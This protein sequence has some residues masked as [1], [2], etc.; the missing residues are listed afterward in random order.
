MRRFNT[1]GPCQ[2]DRHYMIPPER[3]FS[4]CLELVDR[5][6]YFVVHA[7]R[8]TG[9]T[10]TMQALARHLR[11]G[12]RYAALWFS[13]EQARPFLDD[14][15]TTLRGVW[16]SIEEAAR[17]SLPAEL[18]PPPR[19]A[20][21][22]A[23]FLQIQ[24][25][26]WSEACPRPLVRDYKTASGGGPVRAGSSSPFNIKEKSLRIGSFTQ[27]EVRDLYGQ[28]TAET[29]QRF[30][31]DALARAW[32]LSQGQ[33]WLVNALAQKVVED[34]RVPNEDAIGAA[35]IEEAKERIILE[36]ATHLDSLLARLR[37]EPVQRVLEPILAGELPYQD[38]LDDDYQYVTDLGLI[39][40]D[41]P[42][43]IA[44]PIY[45]EIIFRVLAGG[46]ERVQGRRELRWGR[47]VCLSRQ[48]S[49][50]REFVTD[51]LGAVDRD[52]RPWDKICSSSR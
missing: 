12:G 11:D 8:Q 10:T 22:V 37:E 17:A 29:G 50:Y 52:V 2:A 24:L 3:R 35:H 32:E 18:S 1:T 5:Q 20:A 30:A 49:R 6:A 15:D 39:A 33:P 42:V 38:P 13:C 43:R 44:N 19:T 16:S 36:R 23:T 27:D 21:E 40:P 26:R 48:S 31:D 47:L 51:E 9:K 46:A 7:P 45:R 34:L 4:E 28:H 25:S 14:V 41:P